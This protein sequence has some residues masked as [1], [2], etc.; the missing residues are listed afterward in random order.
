MPQARKRPCRICR[1]WFRP[2]PRVGDR[3]RACS[4]PECQAA[5]RQ[6]TQANWRRRNSDYAIAWRLDQRAIQ[7]PGPEPL[8]LPAPLPQLPWDVAKDQFG[9][10]V[11]ISLGLWE[12]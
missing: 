3:Q 12:H 9:A 2:D 10:Q 11:L 6:K 1:H 8:R 7:T 4:Q 5:R